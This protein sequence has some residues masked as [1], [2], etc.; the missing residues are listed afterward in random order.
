[1]LQGLNMNTNIPKRIPYNLEYLAL[2]TA[3]ITPVFFVIGHISAYM[4]FSYFDIDY[5]KFTDT[6]TAFSFALESTGIVI[7]TSIFSF[8]FAVLAR[9][10]F[11]HNSEHQPQSYKSIPTFRKIR[12]GVLISLISASLIIFL[13][14]TSIP[15][16]F[17]DDIIAKRFIPYE[18]AFN[19]GQ[20]IKRCVTPI[21]TI[22]KFQAFITE[23][24]QPLLIRKDN[25]IYIKPLFHPVPLEFIKRGKL[26]PRNPEFEKEMI[27]WLKKWE[28]TCK[29]DL[30]N[31]FEIFNFT[32]DLRH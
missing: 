21:G 32:K 30:D 16:N 11:L 31:D 7:A 27:V 6:A 20:N 2:F 5:F 23:K 13:F 17:K 26:S 18:I 15:L 25:L 19:Q 10:Y 14:I 12:T 28:G 24:F 29:T 8:S 22:G 4:Y 1:M 3:I 9:M